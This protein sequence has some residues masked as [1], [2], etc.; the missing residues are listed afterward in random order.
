MVEWKA[1]TAV[2][3]GTGRRAACGGWH[4]AEEKV[5]LCGWTGCAI[6]IF[7]LTFPVT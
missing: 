2:A 3:R 1:D 4:A 7:L 5:H 6:G